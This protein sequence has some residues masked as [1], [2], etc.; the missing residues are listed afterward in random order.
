MNYDQF[1]ITMYTAQDSDN[2]F[3]ALNDSGKKNFILKIMNLDFSKYKDNTAAQITKLEQE[4]AIIKSKLDGF[5]VNIDIY[6]SNITNPVDIE[7][8][9]QNC[10]A[11]IALAKAE[12]KKLELIQK[13][14]LTKYT[15]AEG[16]IQNKLLNIRSSKTLVN[17]KRK[18]LDRLKN[19]APDTSCPECNVDLNIVDGQAVKVDDSRIHEQIKVVVQQINDYEDDIAQEPH[20]HSLLN[21]IKLK[22][23]EIYKEYQDAHFAISTYNNSISIKGVMIKELDAKLSHGESIRVKVVDIIKQVKAFNTRLDEIGSEVVRE[24]A[25]IDPSIDLVHTA[26]ACRSFPAEIGIRISC[27][28]S[29][30]KVGEAT[31]IPCNYPDTFRSHASQLPY[32]ILVIPDSKR[33]HPDIVF[34]A[35]FF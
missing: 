3:I 12:I 4:E 1:L 22:K 30:I 33:V 28:C 14:D 31:I 17:I 35:I 20:A 26:V 2:N 19:S 29:N 6:K 24:V 11:S 13:P 18:E 16:K 25:G 7:T 27:S 5:K 10:N 34:S 15:E 8:R 23:Q 32:L 9:V 21:K